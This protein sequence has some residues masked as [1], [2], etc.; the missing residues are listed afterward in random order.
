MRKKSF[1]NERRA[2]N[3]GDKIS[4]KEV[5]G[6]LQELVKNQ[7]EA[8]RKRKAELLKQKKERE[9]RRIEDQ[10]Y[11]EKRVIEK[12]KADTIRAK[13]ELIKRNRVKRDQE[14]QERVNHNFNTVYPIYQRL[15]K[16]SMGILVPY[17]HIYGYNRRELIPKIKNALVRYLEITDSNKFGKF[18]EELS[19][20]RSYI[21]QALKNIK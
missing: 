15:R 14:R 5:V 1:S 2:F 9:K 20:N 11:R 17:V 8:K 21:I 16:L 10:K 3:L 18:Q 6:I 4:D 13:K 7:R 19:K 12:E